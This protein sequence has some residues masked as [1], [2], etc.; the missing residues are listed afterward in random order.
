MVIQNLAQAFWRRC[1]RQTGTI[2]CNV[3]IHILQNQCFTHRNTQIKTK[4]ANISHY[5]SP[6]YKN[7][8]PQVQPHE[9]PRKR[10]NYEPPLP[11]QSFYPKGVLR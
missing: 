6:N 10:Q 2:G 4:R 11:E 9:C 7:D 3:G 8:S 1:R 5:F